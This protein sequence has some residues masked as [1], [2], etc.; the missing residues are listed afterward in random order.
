[1]PSSS[2]CVTVKVIG[3]PSSDA[4]QAN[5]PPASA[6]MSAGHETSV[7]AT[8]AWSSVSWAI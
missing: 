4:E 7:G 2:V 3:W 1:L 8:P 6:S 5:V